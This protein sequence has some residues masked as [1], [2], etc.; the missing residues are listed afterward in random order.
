MARTT[1]RELRLQRAGR[2]RTKRRLV[3][4][5]TA[6][7]LLLGSAALADTLEGDQLINGTTIRQNG[8]MDLGEVCAGQDATGTLSLGIRKSQGGAR[9]FA[10]SATVIVAPRP[11]APATAG[12]TAGTTSGNITLPANW[13]DQ[14][15]NALPTGT[16]SEV[17]TATVTLNTNTIGAYSGSVTYRATGPDSVPM[18]PDLTLDDTVPVTANVINCT[19]DTGRAAPA[20][21]NAHINTFDSGQVDQCKR[22][23]GRNWRGDII[24]AIAHEYNPNTTG[25][26]EED[27]RDDVDDYCNF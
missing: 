26:E 3:A 14:G 4:A 13:A 17:V 8:S 19:S 18:T 27:V 10:S 22:T 24:S 21:A 1:R 12:L 20:V 7:L 2:A 25:F 23:L 5:T 15:L 16:L 9:E 6:G 11:T